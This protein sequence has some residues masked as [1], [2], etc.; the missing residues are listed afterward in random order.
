[1]NYKVFHYRYLQADTSGE[2]F[3]TGV[4]SP[5]GFVVPKNVFVLHAVLS[6]AKTLLVTV[7]QHNNG[8]FRQPVKF[9]EFVGSD[10]VVR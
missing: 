10:S 5:H 6:L 1:M 9:C 3:V 8:P 2:V 7:A 4:L